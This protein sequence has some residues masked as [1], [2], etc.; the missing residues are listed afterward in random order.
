[1]YRVISFLVLILSTCMWCCTDARQQKPQLLVKIICDCKQKMV[2]LS[3]RGNNS[4][5]SIVPS[6][7]FLSFFF[8]EFMSCALKLFLELSLICTT[9]N[10]VNLH[11]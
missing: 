1:M 2:P 7:F 11:F 9:D 3:A 8:N 5:L 6:F 4:T 10:K